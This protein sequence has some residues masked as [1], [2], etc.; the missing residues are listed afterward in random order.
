MYAFSTLKRSAFHLSLQTA[1]VFA[2]VTLF[3]IS[4]TYA[5]NSIWSVTNG[6]WSVASNWGGTEPTI[7]RAAYIN[8]GGTVSI[9]AT[10]ESCASLYLA[11]NSSDSGSV[12]MTSRQS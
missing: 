11:L 5:A 9:T 2:V 10:G 4:P 6:D 8:N 3:G 7:A 1:V 12:V